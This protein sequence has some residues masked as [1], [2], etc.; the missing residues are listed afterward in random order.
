MLTVH[1]SGASA[2]GEDVSY[3]AGGRSWLQENPVHLV[4]KSC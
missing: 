4:L 2:A 1:G 3:A